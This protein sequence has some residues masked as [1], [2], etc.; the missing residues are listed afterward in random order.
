M[1]T[2]ATAHPGAK[3]DTPDNHTKNYFVEQEKKILEYWESKQIFAQIQTQSQDNPEFWYY[4]G[5]PF[6]TGLPHHGHLLASTIK[7]TIPRKKEMEGFRVVRHFGWDCHGIPIEHAIDKDLGLSTQEAIAKLGLR[8]YNDACRGIVE[9]YTKEWEQTIKRIGRW[10]D[11]ST[12]YRT[13]DKNFM[14]S[15]WWAAGQLWQKGLIY[16]GTKVMPYSTQLC[17]SISNFEA[18]SNYQNIQNPAITVLFWCEKLQAYLAIWTTTPWTL[19]TNLAICIGKHAYV[20]VFDTQREQHIIVSKDYFNRQ[21][22]G[23]L[24]LIE[25][26]NHT[27]LADNT[28]TP[29]FD[30]FAEHENAFQILVDDYVSTEDGT[31]LVHMAPAHGE[32][33]YRV[34]SEHKI[35]PICLLDQHGCFDQSVS[36]LHG[37]DHRA[38][39]KKIIQMIKTQN[40]LLRHEVIEHSYPCC[41]RTDTPLIYMSIPSWFVN[42]QAIKANLIKHNQTINW[43]PEH[44]KNGRFGKWLEN[45]KDWAISRSRYWGT[46]LP[47]WI[48]DITK[49]TLFI[50]SI[51]MLTRYSGVE[52]D[53]LHRENID[54]I[55]FSLAD[56]PGVYRRIPEV[57]DCWFESASMPFAQFHYPFE[58]KEHFEKIFPADFIAEGIDQT[59][60]WFYTLTVLAGAL[61]DQPAFKNVIVSGI[62][63]A[64]DGKKMSKR[65]QNYTPPDVLLEQYGA[66][67]LRLYLIQSNLVRAE[68]Q[69]FSDHGVKD[70]IRRVLLPWKNAFQFFDTYAKIDQWQ[71]RK[72]SKSDNI[73]DQWIQSRLQSLIEHIQTQTDTYILHNLVHAFCD[74]LDDL[75]NTYIRLNRARFWQKGMPADKEQAYNCLYNVLLDFSTA[76]APFTPFLSETIYLQLQ[77]NYA[78]AQL[79]K[80]SIHMRS[81]PQH[82]AS[83]QKPELEEAVKNM[84]AVLIL[85]RQLRNKHKIKIKTPL[86]SCSIIHSDESLL[87]AIKP[88]HTYIQKELNVK[89]IHIDTNESASIDILVQPNAPKLGKILGPKYPE[90]RAK[91]AQLEQLDIHTFEQNGSIEIAGVK[92]LKDDIIIKRQPKEGIEAACDGQITL[93]MDLELDQELRAEGIAREFIN[94]IQKQRKEDDFNV[95][96]RIQIQLECADE[97][98]IIIEQHQEYIEEETLC[99]NLKF[100]QLETVQSSGEVEGHYYKII[101]TKI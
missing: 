80:A 60:G 26:L 4:D 44:I 53:D 6:A 65:L 47:I 66:D 58:N 94:H 56:Q 37:I 30:Y 79:S 3:P 100:C 69:R 7:D 95:I 86:R 67:A 87:A 54:E 2:P 83:L 74:F 97:L 49:D 57:L 8:G 51:E 9:R 22:E 50:E 34:C 63:I 21:P 17:T 59:R 98:R 11:F 46:P 35:K 18:S 27:D 23:T 1:N 84:Q 13:M 68:E 12:T 15:V 89:N 85:G 61:F 81:Y 43:V 38:A 36:E 5:P 52:V 62:V 90:V 77:A 96:D 70:M 55:T 29:L 48:N 24:T 92:L 76:L 20:K 64:E 91:L 71:P 99:N 42:I 19:P 88:L 10:V 14:E 73:L 40:Q 45:A 32:D 78:G 33:D 25:E 16:Q 31:G 28:Y 101:I 75:T 82:Q 72:H 41:P 93:R 39:N